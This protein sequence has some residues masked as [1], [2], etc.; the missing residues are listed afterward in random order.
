MCLLHIR[1]QL[2]SITPIFFYYNHTC[3]RV[4]WGGHGTYETLATLPQQHQPHLNPPKSFLIKQ[5]LVEIYSNQKAINYISAS[6]IRALPS[7][8]IYSNSLPLPS[9]TFYGPTPPNFARF[10]DTRISSLIYA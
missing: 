10:C 5:H 8:P 2:F 9:L 1:L 7:Y 6:N 3:R 4:K